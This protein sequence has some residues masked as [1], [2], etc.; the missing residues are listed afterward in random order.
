MVAITDKNTSLD[1]K[2]W[3]AVQTRDSKA[4]GRF[5]YGVSSTGIYCRPTCPSRR[6]GPTASHFSLDPLGQS[7]PRSPDS[8]P[9]NA[10]CRIRNPPAPV[11]SARSASTSKSDR[12]NQVPCPPWPNL[13]GRS[14][15]ALRTYSGCS[16]SPP[17]SRRASMRQPSVWT[18]SRR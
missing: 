7:K 2:M 10:A 12:T 8:G 13:A 18:G 4:D 16:K 1:P 14:G 11:W 17:E 6:P 15:A 9:A 3:E 5:V